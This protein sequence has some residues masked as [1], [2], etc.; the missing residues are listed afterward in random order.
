MQNTENYKIYEQAVRLAEENTEESLEKAMQLFRSV[1]GWQDA[2]RQYTSCRTRL[3]RIRWQRESA[4]LKEFEDRHEAKMILRKRTVLTLVVA[5]LL[6]FAVIA[7]VFFVRLKRYNKAASFYVAG[8]YERAAEAFMKME[9]YMDSKARVYL[10]AVELYK[11]H[12]YEEALPY[13]VWLDGY[14]DNGYYLNKCR[15]K[16]GLEP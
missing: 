13:F 14:M 4:I 6:I 16:L 5:V 2:D 10:S 15:E 9:G 1:K 7:C 12:M 11:Q 3:G 8:E